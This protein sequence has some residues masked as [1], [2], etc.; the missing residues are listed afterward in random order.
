MYANFGS[1]VTLLHHGGIFLPKEDEDIAAEIRSN[2]EAQGIQF[3]LNADTQEITSDG[4]VLVEVAG[5]VTALS[6]D[7]ILIAVG[8]RAN[9]EGLHL[10]AAGVEQTERGAVKTNEWRQTTAENIFA[11]G[12][13]VGGLQFTYVSLD[14]Y[15]IVSNY[16]D[17]KKLTVKKHDSMYH[18]AYSWKFRFQE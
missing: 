6:A 8:R 13:V 14:D 17:G 16:L 9:V 12:D 5:S 11:M 18:I 7:A 2:L 10:E 15:R 1:K 3:L 4:N